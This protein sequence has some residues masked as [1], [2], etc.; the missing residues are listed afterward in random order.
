MFTSRKGKIVS[1]CLLA[2]VSL[3]LIQIPALKQFAVIFFAV[4]GIALTLAF[5]QS[6]Q[7]TKEKKQTWLVILIGAVAFL[8]SFFALLI[9]GTSL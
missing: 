6:Y 4:A 9:L 2:S 7:Q 8:V 3:L 1:L 5:Y